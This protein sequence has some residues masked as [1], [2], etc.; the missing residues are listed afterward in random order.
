MGGRYLE[1]VTGAA[2][3]SETLPN[4]PPYNGTTYEVNDSFEAKM[5]KRYRVTKDVTRIAM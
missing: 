4:V 3:M 1:E 2:S 5:P